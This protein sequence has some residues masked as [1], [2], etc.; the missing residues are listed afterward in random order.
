MFGNEIAS[1][2]PYGLHISYTVG[3]NFW[4]L[5]SLL[6]SLFVFMM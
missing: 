5:D 3:H 4:L 1:L 2:H 6:T